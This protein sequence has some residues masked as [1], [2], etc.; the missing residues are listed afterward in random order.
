M[1]KIPL[2]EKNTAF[3]SGFVA[4]AG[5]PNAG[6]S[7]LLNRI[8]GEKISIT[9]KKPQTTR[10]R[11]L[12]VAHRPGSQMV[13]IDTPG[14]H[15][16]RGELNIRIVDVALTALGDVDLVLLVVDLT[17][18][19]PSSEKLL[20]KALKNQKRPVM[21]AL[22]KTD[23]VKKNTILPA[24]ETWSGRYPFLE[25]IPVS[26]KHGSGVEE[27]LAAM[28]NTLPEGP[29][30]FP[31][32]SLTD[33]SYRF[34]VAEMI[35]EKAFR[36]TGQEIPYSVAVTIDTFKE[37]AKKNLTKINAAIHVER[38]SQKGI[39]IG[40]KGAKLKQI[41]ESARKDIEKML[42]TRVYLKL[43]VRVQ[44]NWSRDTKAL[45]RFGY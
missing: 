20:L 27:L 43:F 8:L 35:R 33:L 15:Q 5:A 23:R 28:E 4:I 41:G 10:N 44:K 29:P 2:T 34:L 45:R 38:D 1:Q 16:A 12:G 42:A 11:I 25:I 13:F 19:D 18:P 31:E 6:K 32:D 24:T 22:N 9:S 14:V 40:K 3:R 37:D 7:T 30:F 17:A 21:L 39:I 26:A 36:L